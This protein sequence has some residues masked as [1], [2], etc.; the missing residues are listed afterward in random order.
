MNRSSLPGTVRTIVLIPVTISSQATLIGVLFLL[1]NAVFSQGCALHQ[2]YFGHDETDLSSLQPGVSRI[3]IE[4]VIGPP[5]RIE[6][7]DGV[8]IAWYVYDMG[9]IGTVEKESTA[10]KMI[11]APLFISV[12]VLT[13]GVMESAN[14]MYAHCD[15]ACQKGLLEVCYDASDSLLSAKED[16]LPRSHALLDGCL[17]GSTIQPVVSACSKQRVNAK[18]HKT[19]GSDPDWLLDKAAGTYCPNADLGHADAQLYIGDF[20]YDGVYGQKFNSVRAWVWYSLAAQGGNAQAAEK[21][22]QVTAELSSDQQA[23]AARQLAAWQPGQC[24]Q[25]LVPDRRGQSLATQ[26]PSTITASTCQAW[27]AEKEARKRHNS[28]RGDGG[29]F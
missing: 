9:S 22:T 18:V 15:D 26:Y 2:M 12:D 11:T 27:Q 13:A 6:Q 4:K 19:A 16:L 21:L 10:Y 25:E 20:H 17:Y 23:E 5:E 8:S 28:Y 29:G 3:A 24:A 7:G 1:L 14:A